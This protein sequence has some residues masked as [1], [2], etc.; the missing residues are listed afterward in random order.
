MP[1]F[2]DTY[3]LL[4][5]RFPWNILPIIGLTCIEFNWIDKNTIFSVMKILQCIHD[6]AVKFNDVIWIVRYSLNIESTH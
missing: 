3:I 6:V 1:V 4:D 2:S 5:L